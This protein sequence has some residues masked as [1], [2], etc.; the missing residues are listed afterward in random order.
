MARRRKTMDMTIPGA[1][2][3]SLRESRAW[4]QER[5]A[6]V[7]SISP[8]TVQRA[9]EGA[10]SPQTMSALAEALDVELD[11]LRRQEPAPS[12]WPRISP[13]LGY[14]DADAAI[15][16][17]ER[18]FGFRTKLRVPGPNGTVMHSQLELRDGLV[19]VKTANA[20]LRSPAEIGGAI[21]QGLLVIVDDVDAH[22]AHAKA[23]GAR[24]ACEPQDAYGQRMYEALD[25]EGHHWWFSQML[26]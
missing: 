13:S 3:R 19:M 6:E 4:T 9:E 26:S 7:A 12:K 10:M 18:A 16:F 15:A 25:P 11:A 23:A 21:T 14:V 1:R 8:R 24:I 17:L 20:E 5:L 2:I 22:H